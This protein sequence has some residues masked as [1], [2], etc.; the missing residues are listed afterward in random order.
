MTRS[1][2]R[3]IGTFAAAAKPAKSLAFLDRV[4]AGW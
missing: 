2:A 3:L 1:C 4:F